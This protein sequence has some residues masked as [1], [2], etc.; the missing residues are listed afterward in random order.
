MP[1]SIP[2]YS[3]NPLRQAIREAYH[4]DEAQCVDGLLDYFAEQSV[5]QQSIKQTAY[6]L[7]QTIR[8]NNEN[9]GGL[10]A[11]L[12]EFK[13]S[14]EEGIAMMCLAEALLRIPDGD[15][16]DALIQDK[17]QDGD[18]Q[19]HIGNSESLFVNASSWGLMLT[20][21]FVRLNKRTVDNPAQ[22]LS[23]LVGQTGELV[24][25]AAM[26]KAMQIMG[27]QFVLAETMPAALKRAAKNEQKGYLYS[28]DMLGEAARTTKDAEFYFQSYLDAIH[29]IGKNQSK[30][31]RNIDPI[32]SPG[33]SVKLSALHPRYEYAQEQRVM[34]ELLPKIVELC[35]IAA[36]YNIGLTIDAEESERLEPSL[37]ILEGLCRDASLQ[38]WSGLGFVVQAY[39]KRALPVLE[40]IEQLAAKHN[41]RMMIRLVKGA[42]WD[43]EIKH[44]QEQ[45][46]LDYPVYTQKF[47]TDVAYLRCADKLLSNQQAFYPLFAT[48]N[49]HTV[50]SILCKAKPE[51]DYEFQCLHGMGEMLYQQVIE[52][53]QKPVRVYAPVGAHKDLLAYLV[54]RLLENG[55]N[56]SFVNRL[57]DKDLPIEEIIGDPIAKLKNSEH[58]RHPKIALPSAL[59]SD[60]HNSS[61]LNLDDANEISG[62]MQAF[63]PLSTQSWQ[64]QCDLGSEKSSAAQMHIVENP[65]TAQAVGYAMPTSAKQIAT[66]FEQAQQHQWAWD[67]RRGNKRAGIL[68]EAAALFERHR[69]ELLTLCILEA[70][71]TLNDAIAELREAVDFLRYY[72]VQARR[73]FTSAKTLHGPTGERNQHRLHGRGV[74][75]C[76]SPWNFPLAIF[77]GQVSAALAA[78]NAVLAKPAEQTPLVAYRAVELLHQAGV[79]K[80]VLHLVPGSGSQVGTQLTA[81]PH[82]AGLTFTGSTQTAQRILQSITAKE[83]PIV[84]FIAETGGLNAM[85]ADSST[86]IEQLVDD[87]VQSAFQSAG[88]RCS[89]LRVLYVQQEIYPQ[90]VE[91]LKGAMDQLITGNPIKLHTDVGPIIDTEALS[92]LNA[93]V[94][95]MRIAG[96]LLYRA[97]SAQLDAQD[98]GHYFAPA[99]IEIEDI[100]QLEQEV[101]GPI[102]HITPYDASKLDEVIA[103]INATGFGLTFG[104]HSRVDTTVDYISQRIKAGNVYVNRNTIGAV[105]GVQP[106]GGEGLSGTGPKAGGPHYLNR[107][108]TERV[109]ST[110]TSAAGGNASLLS[111]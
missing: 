65:A 16:A 69:D 10:D 7:V 91:K 99:L 104:I 66:C 92:N 4:R 42:Y 61:G 55:A 107:F 102:L 82:I 25:R 47:T 62:F 40:W 34:D 28:Y 64:A 38:A 30:K 84:P 89:A 43:S 15:T 5:D 51:H 95:K 63:E 11:F 44:A 109:I 32:S 78:G 94:D 14:S 45:G 6:D 97:P 20:G 75:V 59:F 35:H 21:K 105:V 79:P 31:T 57:V 103:N 85:I 77:A 36:Q 60:R 19:A 39:Q 88:Q 110:N 49:A 72:A 73:H 70:G 13:L 22:Y 23:R 96:H 83:G 98:K 2:F 87:V 46:Y 80:E 111:L 54:R 48:H 76:I 106:F 1:N 67:A 17:L 90:V 56:S 86:L 100:E 68:E 26:T 81:L 108:A 58:K 12:Q 8:N 3:E 9:H 74:F 50:A 37:A 71:K 27:Q 29:A 24:I 93:H 53:R 33:I 18:W 52:Q 101:F 41:R